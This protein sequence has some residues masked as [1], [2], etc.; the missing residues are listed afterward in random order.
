MFLKKREQIRQKNNISYNVT[1]NAEL[2]KYLHM[3]SER[4]RQILGKLI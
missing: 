1:K 2:K 3:Q 4:V